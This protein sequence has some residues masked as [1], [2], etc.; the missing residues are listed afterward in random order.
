[1]IA[2]FYSFVHPID[3]VPT[4]PQQ[5]TDGVEDLLVDGA[6]FN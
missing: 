5:T 1:M 6:F 3:I 4:D 2:N